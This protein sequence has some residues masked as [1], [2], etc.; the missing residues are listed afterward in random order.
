MDTEVQRALKRRV[1]SDRAAG[2]TPEIEIQRQC[3]IHGVDVAPVRVAPKIVR[4][5][6][7]KAAKKK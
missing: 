1:R 4:K 3:A 2:I 6:R 7:K 5:P